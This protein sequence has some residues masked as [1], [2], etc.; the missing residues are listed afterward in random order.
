MNADLTPEEFLIREYPLLK[1]IQPMKR[2]I[3]LMEGYAKYKLFKAKQ[4]LQKKHKEELEE[5]E[6]EVIGFAEWLTGKHTLT[7]IDLHR[8]Y[9]S[10]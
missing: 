7:L 1:D 8:I 2:T 5:L 6:N 4:E 10:T 9:K 3:E